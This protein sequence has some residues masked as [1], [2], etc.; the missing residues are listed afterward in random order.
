MCQG[1]GVVDTESPRPDVK[2]RLLFRLCQELGLSRDDRHELATHAL[3]R[4]ITSWAQLG[5]ADI[6][7][8]L[9]NVLG[10]I[11]VRHLLDQRTVV[12]PQ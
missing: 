3:N 4:D 8:L 2:R 10:F 6:D 7:R 5:P 1:E 9:D 11:R 12:P